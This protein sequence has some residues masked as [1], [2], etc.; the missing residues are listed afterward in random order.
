MATK[1]GQK[2]H[3]SVLCNREIFRMYS[4]DFG[5]VNFSMLSE[6]V[7]EPRELSW[8][9]NLNKNKPKLHCFQFFAKNQGLF[10]MNSQ[11]FGSATSNMLSQFSREPRELP[12]QPNSEKK[13][14]KITQISVSCK[15]SRNFLHVQ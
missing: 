6:F 4:G 15:K 3:S 2:L 12:W 9:P 13:L 7:R 10:R 14:A 11:V 8:Q 1:F 5:L